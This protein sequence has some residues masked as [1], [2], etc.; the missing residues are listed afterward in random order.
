VAATPVPPPPTERSSAPRR[1][2]KSPLLLLL[3]LTPGIPEYLT[4]SSSITALFL[5]PAGFALQFGLNAALYTAGA[6]LIR[7]A[8]IRWGKGWGS[9]LLLGAAYGIVEEG[10]A[11]HTFFQAGGNPVGILG[12]YGRLFGVNWVWV[13]GLTVFHAV[14]SIAL[15]LL[16]LGLVYPETTGRPL[17]ARRGLTVAAVAYL[18]DVVLLSAIVP[19]HP[20]LGQTAFFLGV[21]GLLVLLAYRLPANFLAPRP[22]PSRTSARRLGLL[23]SGWF[24]LWILAGS[25]LPFTRLPAVADAAILGAGELGILFVLWRGVG[26]VE[27]EWSA[28]AFAT[29][30]IAVLVPWELLLVVQS[31][32]LALVLG[33]VSVVALVR[34]RR[35]VGARTFGRTGGPP[36]AG[37]SPPPGAVDPGWAG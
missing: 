32:P 12:A 10:L 9:V 31:D 17:L 19:S 21:I 33:I 28:L 27:A 6:L 24:L 37:P 11:V 8:V 23:G 7:E 16:I 30:L 2:W 36:V 34:L 29:G 35:P 20:N 5:N 25:F 14:Y 18:A 1:W 26:A 15:P 3:L 22:G 4:G 13:S